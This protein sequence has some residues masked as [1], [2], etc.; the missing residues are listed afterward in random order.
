MNLQECWRGET[1]GLE[2]NGKG[3]REVKRE[4][5]WETELR[6]GAGQGCWEQGHAAAQPK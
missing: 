3:E 2:R 6:E 1:E 4:G 5:V